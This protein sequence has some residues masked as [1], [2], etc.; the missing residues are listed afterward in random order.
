M[1]NTKESNELRFKVCFMGLR[2]RQN[3]LDTMNAAQIHEMVTL[4]LK[5][6]VAIA[7]AIEAEKAGR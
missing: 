1:N 5:E 6:L 4:P 3:D 7:E 2:L